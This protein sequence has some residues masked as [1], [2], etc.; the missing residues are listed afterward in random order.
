VVVVVVLNVNVVVALP[1]GY[2]ERGEKKRERR[3][4]EK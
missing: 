1:L 2:Q 4:G 3:I